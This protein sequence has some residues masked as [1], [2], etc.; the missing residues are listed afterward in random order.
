MKQLSGVLVL[1]AALVLIVPTV[2]ASE[3]WEYDESESAC[4][5]E[6]NCIWMSDPWGSWC[7]E[8]G[9]WNFEDN[10][11]C[12]QSN[13][14][15]NMSCNWMEPQ[16]EGG[17]CEMLGCWAYDG[18]SESA[19]ENNSANISCTWSSEESLC[20]PTA[21]CNEYST[22]NTCEGKTGFNAKSCA[23]DGTGN[24]CYEQSCHNFDGD[25]DACTNATDHLDCQWNDPYCEEKGCW[26]Y[27]DSASCTSAG[28]RWNSDVRGWCEKPQCWQYDNISLGGDANE[29]TCVNNSAGLDCVWDPMGGWCYEN[30]TS[31]CES[32]TNERDC[33]DTSWCWWDPINSTCS[34][35]QNDN[36]FETKNPGCFIFGFSNET[37][38]SV[39]GCTWNETEQEC[40]GLE[41]PGVQCANITNSTMCNQIP[42]LGSCCKWTQ[43]SCQQTFETTCWDQMEEPPEGAMFCEDYNAYG[44]QTLCEQIAG[45]PWYMPCE[46]NTATEH[47]Q[48]KADKFFGEGESAKLIEIDNKQNCEAAGGQWIPETYCEGTTA[49]PAGRCEPKFDAE[50]NCDKAC[51]AC[52][53]QADGSAWDSASAAQ[54]ACLESERGCDFTSSSSAP[55]GLGFCKAQ[56]FQKSGMLGDCDSDCPSCTYL[57][58]PQTAC[59]NSKASCT[60]DSVNQVCLQKGTKTCANTCDRCYDSTTCTES[61]RGGNSACSWDEATDI[62]QPSSG[63]TEVCWNGA[64]DDDDDMIDCADSACFGDPACGGDDMGSDCF[65]YETSANC[66]AADGCAWMEDAWGGWCDFE[67][68]LC[69]QHDGN[70]DSCAAA[71]TSCEWYQ[72]PGGGECEMNWSLGEQC[73]QYGGNQSA[74]ENA[75]ENCT[76]MED[77]FGGFCEYAPLAM[78]VDCFQFDGDP[79]GCDAADGCTWFADEFGGGWCDPAIGQE[80]MQNENLTDNETACNAHELCKWTSGWC[81]PIGF[82]GKAMQDAGFEGKT[83]FFYNDN[84]TQCEN[85]T[86]CSFFENPSGAFCDISKSCFAPGLMQNETACEAT[87][88]CIFENMTDP[89]GGENWSECYPAK[90]TCFR[91]M[92]LQQNESACNANSN[93]NWTMGHCEPTCF[94]LSQGDCGSET[95]CA[96]IEGFCEDAAHISDFAE[97]ERGA[98]IMLGD[99]AMGDANSLSTDLMGFGVKDMGD[100][101]GFGSGVADVADS[102][103]C[104]GKQLMDGGQGQGRRTSKFYLYLDTDGS[105]SGSCAPRHDDDGT[106]Y[107]FLYTYRA[108]MSSDSGTSVSETHTAYRCSNGE[109]VTADLGMSSFSAFICQE[110]GGPMIAVDKDS[111]FKFPALYDPAADM[112]VLV[113]TADNE[114]N[115]SSPSDIA[116]PG[117]YTPGAID[118]EV[119]DMFSYGADT[120]MLEDVLQQ[121]FLTFEDCLNGVDDDSDGDMDCADFDCYFAK[122]CEDSSLR[123]SA[124]EDTTVPRIISAKIETYPDSVLVM[125]DTNKPANGTLYFYGNDSTCSD[126]NDTIYDIG[127]TSDESLEYKSWHHAHVYTDEL[128]FEL[129]PATTYY[130]KL[131]IC[132]WNGKCA[133]SKCSS[134]KTAQSSICHY[135][136]FVTRLKVPNGWYVTYDVDQDG[137]DTHTQ[138]QVCGENAGMKTNYTD[139]R[140]VDIYLFNNAN[141]SAENA[142]GLIFKNTTLT[143]SAL[144]DKVRDIDSAGDIKAGTS[145]SENYAGLPRETRDKI[146]NNLHPEVCMVKFPRP[147]DGCTE[148]WHCD[149]DLESCELRSDAT[150]VADDGTHCT[151]KIPYCEFSVWGSGDLEESAP[152]NTPTGGSSSPGGGGGAGLPIERTNA[153]VEK[154]HTWGY[155]PAGGLLEYFTNDD[156]VSITRIA[157]TPKEDLAQPGVTLRVYETPPGGLVEMP[158]VYQYLEIDANG[159][160]AEQLD[161]EVMIGF[162]VSAAWLAAQGIAPESVMLRAWSGSSWKGLETQ[163]SGQSLSQEWYTYESASDGFGYLLIAGLDDEEVPAEPEPAVELQTPPTPPEPS[164]PE[165]RP[166]QEPVPKDSSNMILLLVGVLAIVAI[167]LAFYGVHHMHHKHAPTSEQPKEQPAKKPEPKKR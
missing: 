111:L 144:N 13:E 45:A 69:W 20:D 36:F 37:C 161:G 17:W 103:M 126:L 141:M 50:R 24:Y 87:S 53:Y 92:T 86:G 137:N 129:D 12:A 145:N 8:K 61:G 148:L 159:V 49:V 3:C 123:P 44:S 166:T 100:A 5:A 54:T 101:L 149:D 127:V 99:D 58:N 83:C 120:A 102:A 133:Q 155:S 55:N 131:R 11:S 14:T 140:K 34:D 139:G 2:L 42:M 64:D 72:P 82:G 23:W 109:W 97:M 106:G 56:S 26:N 152:T 116:G 167:V 68:A 160:G 74:C 33:M 77:D 39:D 63:A 32:F 75:T 151:W 112:R 90:E 122:N 124:S 31:D 84:Q 115:G 38:E 66:D 94:G 57:N 130:Y 62:C 105:R 98:P 154:F 40:E 107:E 70:Q 134:F 163:L 25:A 95:G 132:D 156:R 142:S 85:T 15:I 89:M 7:E 78:D 65:V 150:L 47:C 1:I 118:F 114:T 43:G 35:P 27:G 4:N 138:G 48:F 73:W 110:I 143:K 21:R 18:S 135:C 10:E 16:G 104:N 59:D 162:A 29:S 88:G 71:N 60:W 157:F 164:P 128:G 22:Q 165:P 136:K 28:C 19:C 119:N 9:C 147:T 96:W 79:T 41:Q 121:G 93:C 108:Q 6:D 51:F 52:E 76:W 113:A 81:D 117:W 80:C 91:N 158:Q 46:W 146:I 125:Y 30:M 153:T 67:G